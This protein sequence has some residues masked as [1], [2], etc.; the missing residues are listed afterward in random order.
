MTGQLQIA[1]RL[2]YRGPAHLTNSGVQPTGQSSMYGRI[3]VED[4]SLE[5]LLAPDQQ[6]RAADGSELDLGGFPPRQTVF[7]H[8]Q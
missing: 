4:R 7:Q 1:V 8:F 2:R 3:D 6:R 5:T